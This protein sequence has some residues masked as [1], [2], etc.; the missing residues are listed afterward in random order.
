ME[1]KNGLLEAGCVNAEEIMAEYR[2]KLP[3]VTR[4]IIKSCREEKCNSHVDY[5]PIPSKESARRH[6]V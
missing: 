5:D 6:I 3:D 1:E 4:E 2:K